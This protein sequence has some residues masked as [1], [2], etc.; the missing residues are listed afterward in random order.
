M[1]AGANSLRVVGDMWGMGRVIPPEALVEYEAG[2]DERIARR[3]P[4]VSLC[5]YDARRF[6]SLAILAALRGHRDT[7][8]YP[9][10]RL[11]G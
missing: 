8:R 7:F 1:R 3:F 9:I 10:E 2:Y 6:S 4:V 11:L 5:Q